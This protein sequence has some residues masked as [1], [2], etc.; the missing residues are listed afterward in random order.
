M[1]SPTAGRGSWQSGALGAV[2]GAA[3]T[4]PEGRLRTLRLTLPKGTLTMSLPESEDTEEAEEPDESSW[5]LGR[6]K[7]RRWLKGD[8]GSRRWGGSPS[9]ALTRSFILILLS[10]GTTQPS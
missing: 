9:Q 3:R 8:S 1:G 2:W 10:V 5:G 7:V 4:H 6:D